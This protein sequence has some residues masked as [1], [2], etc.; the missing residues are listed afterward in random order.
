MQHDIVARFTP[1]A[2]HCGSIH[3]TFLLWI[4]LHAAAYVAYYVGFGG[5]CGSR[6]SDNYKL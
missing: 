2:E 6:R 3:P 4:L 5:G 1:K